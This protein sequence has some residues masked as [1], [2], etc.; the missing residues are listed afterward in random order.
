MKLKTYESS[1]TGVWVIEPTFI[2][3]SRGYFYE[4]YNEKD[5]E[6]GVRVKPNFV[7]D[8]HSKS[9]KNVLRGLHYQIYKPQGKL[10]RVIQGEIF[11]VAVDIRVDSPNFG[12]WF[13]IKLSEDNRKQLWIPPDFAHGFL[14]TSSEAQVIYKTTEF[15]DPDS[16]K[17]IIW[18]DD[19]INIDWPTNKSDPILS[20][21]DLAG[22]SL[23]DAELPKF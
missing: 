5:F 11:D 19:T 22:L 20:L 18:N 1:L 2:D 10:V 13:G 3:D 23:N 12:S 17:T 7:Q 9:S 16:E 21:K 6:I 8:N 14:V 15:Y 4:S